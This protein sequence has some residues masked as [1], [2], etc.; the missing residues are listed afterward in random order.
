M[1]S[2]DAGIFPL[3]YNLKTAIGGP[4]DYILSRNVFELY[5]VHVA[6]SSFLSTM[7]T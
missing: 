6:S 3:Y 1:K 2:G 7:H 5:N 4:V